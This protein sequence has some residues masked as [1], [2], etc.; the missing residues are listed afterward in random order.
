V[1]FLLDQGLPRSLAQLMA[2]AGFPAT[3]VATLNMSQADDSSIIEHAAQNRLICITLDADF[4]AIVAL[5]GKPVPSIIRFRIEGL[6][7]PDY[8]KILAGLLPSIESDLMA[9]AF[10]SVQETGVRLRRLPLA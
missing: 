3:H 8:L 4:Q 5:S 1:H 2:E 6:K 7:A 10:V 9:G